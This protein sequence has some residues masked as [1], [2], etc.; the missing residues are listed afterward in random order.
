MEQRGERDSETERG[1][2]EWRERGESETERGERQWDI[3]GREA[4]RQRGEERE[5]ENLIK[6]G[7]ASSSSK[8]VCVT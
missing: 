5:T 2:R 1:E 7:T 6:G 8:L 3:E 4:V